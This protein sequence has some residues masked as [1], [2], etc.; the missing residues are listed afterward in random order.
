MVRR[1]RLAAGR[2]RISHELQE[3]ARLRILV[4]TSTYLWWDI[5]NVFWFCPHRVTTNTLAV[6]WVCHVVCSHHVTTATRKSSFVFQRSTHPP[7]LLFPPPRRSLWKRAII[8][9]IPAMSLTFW[10]SSDTQKMWVFFCEVHLPSLR[11]CSVTHVC[12]G[13][14]FCCG[15]L[16]AFAR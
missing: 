5:L 12:A 13:F 15:V 11:A 8:H 10:L 2:A 4:A 6:A 16:S 9:T 14:P 1:W 3:R 7:L